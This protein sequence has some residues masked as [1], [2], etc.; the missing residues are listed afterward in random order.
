MIKCVVFDFD[1]TLVKSNE[2]KRRVFYEVT[3]DIVDAVPVL[4]EL[5]SVP[6]SGD[7]YN[8]FDL[9]IKNLKLVQEVGVTASYLSSLYT[10][11]C[12]HRIS[13]APEVC[14]AFN[15]LTELK[16]IKVKMFV[17]SATPTNTLQRIIGMRGWS[18]LFDGIM[19]SPDSKEEHLKSILIS[20]N[21]SL[22]EVVYIGDSEVDQKAALL[23]GCKFI[24]IGKNWNR[25]DSRPLVLLDTLE[26]LIKELKL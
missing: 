15:A 18:E 9:L 1:G 2:I 13:E 22:S 8:I 16:K 19:G 6:D 10:K 23:I 26:K 12:E 7:R 14:G 20:N 17:S 5:F 25:F 4:D 11:I 24:G 21:Y 3:E